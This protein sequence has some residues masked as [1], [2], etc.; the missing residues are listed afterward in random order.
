MRHRRD[1]ATLA[2]R[3]LCW[4]SLH[5]WG[6]KRSKTGIAG[7]I[8]SCQSCGQSRWGPW[9]EKLKPSPASRSA[10]PPPPFKGEVIQVRR[11]RGPLVQY[12]EGAEINTGA[13]VQHPTPKPPAAAQNS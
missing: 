3:L 7:W 11:P 10:W 5:L 9:S 13:L 8:Q 1:P 4:L 6:R 2:H 12:P